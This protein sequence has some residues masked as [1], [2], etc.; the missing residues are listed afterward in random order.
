MAVVSLIF[1]EMPGPEQLHV[2]SF[3]LFIFTVNR[4]GGEGRDSLICFDARTFR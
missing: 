1:S 4:G 2:C 3:H